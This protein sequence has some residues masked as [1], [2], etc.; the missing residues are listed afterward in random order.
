MRKI[1]RWLG[2]SSI[3]FMA[4]A[5][6]GANLTPF[7]DFERGGRGDRPA[8]FWYRAGNEYLSAWPDWKLTEEQKVSGRY[9]VTTDTI[10]EFIVC[11]ETMPGWI[12]GS[13]SLRADKPGT[14]IVIR[15]SWV[16]RSLNR[17]D[18]TETVEVG[19]AWEKHTIKVEAIGDQS[20]ELAVHAEKAGTRIW[21]DDFVIDGNPVSDQFTNNVTVYDK[22]ETQTNAPAT[23]TPKPSYSEAQVKK[24]PMDVVRAKPVDIAKLQEYA[25]EGRDGQGRVG[26][27]IDAPENAVEMPYVT[28]GVPFPRGKLFHRN[29][30]RLV[31]EG[32]R[33]VAA[34]FDVLSRWPADG[35]IMALLVTTPLSD[36][37][38]RLFLEFG[39]TV[40]PAEV[41]D[42]LD[43]KVAERLP[44]LT[45]SVI[46]AEGEVYEPADRTTRA[47]LVG[48]LRMIWT[49][50][51]RLKGP[52]GKSAGR[53]VTRAT[54]WRGSKRYAVAHSWINDEKD[55]SIPIRGAGLKGF[56]SGSSKAPSLLTQVALNKVFFSSTATDVVL[57]V[58]PP[59]STNVIN[60]ENGLFGGALA[61]RDFWQNHPMA[62]ESKADGQVVW[63]WP[64]TVRGVFIPQGFARQ[65][66]FLVDPDGGLKR[67]YATVAMPILRPDPQWMCDSGV[68][69]FIMP[70]DPERFPIFEERVN[71]MKVLGRFAL[72]EKESRNLYGV[73]NY[74]DAP[75]GDVWSNLES[76][77]D[78]ELFLHWMRGKDREHYDM[79]RLAAEHYRDIDIHHGA[80][81]AHTHCFNHVAADE[82]WSHAWIQ[83]L[84]D[85]Y[86]LQGDLGSLETLAQMGERLVQKPAGFA[87]G[88]D[89]TRALDDMV[90]I[91][92]VTGDP[93][94]M[95]ALKEQFAEL[96]RRQLPE[97]AVTGAERFSWYEDRYSAGCA[98]TW[99]GC[100]AMA[101][102]HLLTNDAD[103]LDTLRREMD[104]SLDV[105][106]KSLRSKCILPGEKL[107]QDRQA[108][109]LGDGFALGR[110]STLFPPLGYLSS[111][112]GD[113]NYLDLGMKILAYYMLNLRSGT[114]NSA[115]AY[116]T[117]FLR[118]A[119][120]AGLGATDEA[121]AFKQARDFSY[122][123]WP[124]GVA[125]GGFEEDNFAYWGVKKVP[126]ANFYYD[127]LVKVGYYL[128]EKVKH[129][130]RR[131]LR[132]HS[133]N[134]TRHMSVE[135]CFA[136]EPERRYR[137]SFWY[138]ADEAMQPSWGLILREYDTDNGSGVSLAPTGRE[139]GGWKEVAGNFTT[140][141]RTVAK[142][143]LN[144]RSGT[145]D[146]W[147]DDVAIEDKGKALALLTANGLGRE[148]DKK[149]PPYPALTLDTGGSYV[150]DKPMSETAAKEGE[151]ILFTKGELTDGA[152]GGYAY[153]QKRDSGSILFDL[154]KPF[155]VRQVR[156]NV[157]IDERKAHGVKRIEL[158]LDDASGKL[159]GAIEPAKNGWNEFDGLDVEA[160]KLAVVV[161]K[162]E[163]RTYLTL[164]EVE[165]WGEKPASSS[166]EAPRNFKP[167]LYDRLRETIL[168]FFRSR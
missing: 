5:G 126:G 30:V 66:D 107:T 142:I 87:S 70:P 62:V 71:V 26:L 79:A 1:M 64:E 147:F 47:E 61:V 136:L 104:L 112:T 18:Q 3:I 25:G 109:E 46:G 141:A 69:E 116:A 144:N 49:V 22:C 146:A 94:Y 38:G 7:G 140:G 43:P 163:G 161:T 128:D 11:G 101:K 156:V 155:P 17:I 42:Q 120:D 100:Q 108:M 19:T 44:I 158:R 81:F 106:T 97:I 74:G 68:F 31:D 132:L 8:E 111:A 93:K 51:G 143:L 57:P 37:A 164:S 55:T 13:V 84:R 153:W 90:D 33:E 12:T 75:G 63:L 58:A 21:A 60:R 91:Y 88:R 167:N 78:H 119:R 114:D 41:A 162:L 6:W 10:R 54:L 14:K 53:Y 124:K 24:T 20:M 149:N 4:A 95:A 129:S 148:P 52:G 76:M 133:D 103:I 59:A 34:Q 152:N 29:C 122:E 27:T 89:W 151:P 127:D 9:S 16:N 110:G 166:S 23:G 150:A 40:K 77:A 92:S 131:S 117:I 86:F 36:K 165:I 115:T 135:G 157:M 72:N 105:Q 15:I 130:G 65:W 48:P 39:P 85:L 138:R 80:G 67:P 82:G 99:Y 134:R 2:V 139:D 50:E 123:R 160:Q 118:Y 73:F 168:R 145:G 154:K 121:K 113:R 96:R 32:G 98:F 45:P 125:N 102:L 35:S 83:G 56:P 159:L 137:A 28:G